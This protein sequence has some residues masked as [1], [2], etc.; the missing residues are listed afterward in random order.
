MN[1]P[2]MPPLA[3]AGGRVVVKYSALLRSRYQSY[4]PFLNMGLLDTQTL[5]IAPLLNETRTYGWHD[6]LLLVHDEQSQLMAAGD[7]LVN[8]HQDNVN[9]V[10]LLTKRGLAEPLCRNVHEVQPGQPAALWAMYFAGRPLPVGW[11]WFARGTAVY[12]GGSVIDVPVVVAGDRLFYLPT[13][14]INAGCCLIAYQMQKEGKAS[15]QVQLPPGNIP[16]KNWDQLLAMKWDWDILEMSRLTPALAGLPQ[17]PAGTRLAPLH[18]EAAQAVAA[19]RDEELDE[20][21]D[22]PPTLVPIAAE[23]QGANDNDSSAALRKR[24]NEAVDELL[25][26]PWQPLRFPA[27]KHPG[28]AYLVFDDPS[29][30][31][32]TL[33]LAWPLL[34]ENRRVKATARVRAL[35]AEGGAFSK[36]T[37][38]ADEGVVRSRFDPA[39]DHLVK[40]APDWRRS[41]TARLYPLWLWTHVTDN[42]EPILSQWPRWREQVRFEPQENEP[43]LGNSRLAGLIAAC[44]LAKLAGDEAWLTEARPKIRAA[45][46]ERLRYELAHTEGGLIT[47]APVLR[48]MLGRWRF[49][50]PDVAR[51]LRRYARPIHGRLMEVY[52][53]YHR[54]TWWLAWN[55]ELLWRNETPLSFPTTS[56]DIFTARS[57]ILDEPSA[58]IAKYLDLPWC[59]AD[60]YFL[61]KLSLTLLRW[62]P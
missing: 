50:T 8:T 17:K 6:S 16:E 45:L 40:Y 46:R 12:G 7:L 34:D 35:L 58:K 61:Q 49:L 43:D 11:E 24:L 32:Y 51:L 37:Y 62:E 21:I 28:E 18:E 19:I 57:L 59:R 15:Q 52:V 23:F 41:A 5:R 13:H 53:D 20:L 48:T 56:L 10:D 26:G 33:A 55:V 47:P 25:G 44:R 42:A 31:L 14:E 3:L 39:P 27:G 2:T 4:S 38:P 29:E 54:P 36:A 30:T 1:G 22:S 9:A 60:E